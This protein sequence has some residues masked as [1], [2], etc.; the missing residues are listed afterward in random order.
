[1]S[2]LLHVGISTKDILDI[3]G[4]SRC[5]N[6]KV[7]NLAKEGKGLQRKPGSGGHN[8]E[9]VTDAEVATIEADPTMSMRKMARI[10]KV[11]NSMMRLQVKDIGLKSYIRRHCQLLSKASKASWLDRGTKLITWLEHHPS[12]VK[13]FSDKILGQLTK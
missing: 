12:T 8:C 1:M 11:S 6:Y 5:F 13:I 4:C 2:D 10:L 7:K 3:V 9:D